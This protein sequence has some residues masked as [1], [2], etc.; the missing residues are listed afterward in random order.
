MAYGQARTGTLT[1]IVEDSS[2]AIVPD[3]NVTLKD[4]LSGVAWKTVSNTEGYFTIA[5]VPPGTYT[6]T[7]EMRGFKRWERTGIT[8]NAGDK[9]HVSDIMLEIGPTTTEVTVSAVAETLAPVD[10]GE[11]SAVITAKQIQNIS[12]LG[13]SA[14]ELI[15][16]LPGMSFTGNGLENKPGFSGEAIGINGNGDGGRQSPIGYYSANGQRGNALDIVADGAHVSDPGCN[17]AIPINPNVDMIQEFKVLQSNYSA[18]H[19]KG[20]VVIDVVAK[21]GG[22]DFHGEGYFYIRDYRMNSNEPQLKAAGQ[23]KPHNK[24]RFPGGNIGGPVLIPGTDF[25][26]NRDKMFFFAA[27]EYYQQTIDTGVLRAQVPTAAMRQ[28]DF[29]GVGNYWGSSSSWQVTGIPKI[30]GVETPVLT[31]N[32]I[33]PG[34]QVLVNLLPPPN[35]DPKGAGQGDNYVSAVTLDQPMHQML[36]RVDYNLSD[37]TKLFVRYNLQRETQAFPVGFWWRN[38]NQVPYPTSIVGK[39]V[40]DALSVSLTRVFNPTLT[41]E[42]VFGLTYIN[43]PNTFEDPKKI[44]RT[45]L[46]Y[47]YQGIFKN[48]LEQIPSFT[49]WGGG[50]PTLYNPG[51]F[52]PV[53]FAKKWLI[54][55]ADNLSKVIGT[56]TLKFGGYAEIVTN[57]QPNS[58]NSNGLVVYTAWGGNT[59][60]NALADLLT[61][62]AAQY[63]EATKNNLHNEGFKVFEAYAQDSW[64]ATPRLTLEFGVRLSHLGAWYDR[65]GIGMAIFDPTTYSNDPA[66]LG[67]LTGLRWNKID[68]S[69]PLS[70]N[71][72][73]SLFVA[74]RVSAAYDLFGNGMTVLRGGVAAYRYHEPQ[75]GTGAL[76]IPAGFRDTSVGDAHMLADLENIVPGTVRTNVNVNDAKD[77]QQPVNYNWNFTLSQRLPAAILWE[78]SYVGNKSEHLNTTTFSNINRVP[79]GAMLDDPNGDPSAYRPLRNYLDINILTHPSYQN[80]HSLQTTIARQKGRINWSANYTFSKTMGIRDGHDQGG[81]AGNPFNILDNYGPLGYDRTHIFNIS[82]VIQLPDFAKSWTGSGAPVGRAILDGWQFSGITQ[83]ASGAN[84]Q[85]AGGSV[86]LNFSAYMPD[87]KTQMNNFRVVGTDAV[88]LMPRVTCDPGA[89]L[90]EHQYINGACFAIPSVGHNGDYVFPYAAG[91]AFVNHDLSVFKNWTLKEDKKLQFRFSA[92]NFLNHPLWSFTAGDTNLNLEFN[93]NGN[94]KNPNFGYVQHKYGH[95]TLQLALKFFF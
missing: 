53:L 59:T 86:N 20:P 28:G 83:F 37:N 94:L 50:L 47:P 42:T 10:S 89:A 43:F 95:R 69:V 70:G 41:N 29:S 35:V 58:G 3:A 19:A 1:G 17:C 62:R 78:I 85:A 49:A 51:G 24:Y 91:P 8:F 2:H 80:Y 60:G 14:A 9:R 5:A 81:S 64:K 27:Y 38:P 82:Y 65:E 6:L 67:K 40:S 90:H 71:P 55:G 73:R 54:S 87:R 7:V 45:A 93:Q 4:E 32:Q 92:Y 36:A 11:K 16:V 63:S 18:E 25:N 79:I 12:V 61:G 84:I 52:D 15:K 34:G 88:S 23:G 30:G 77:D 26:K 72:S 22:R 46:G 31:A 33:D 13:R 44:S 66:D 56:H 57:N 48:G 68:S 76:D 74:P 39:N 21:S 75:L